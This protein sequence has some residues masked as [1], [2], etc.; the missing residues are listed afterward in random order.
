MIQCMNNL[1]HTVTLPSFP[2]LLIIILSVKFDWLILFVYFVHSETVR[3][4]Y[5]QPFVSTLTQTSPWIVRGESENNRHKARLPTRNRHSDAGHRDHMARLLHVRK[6]H[7]SVDCQKIHRGTQPRLYEC[8][9]RGQGVWSYHQRTLSQ[10]ALNSATEHALWSKTGMQT[11]GL[12][13]TAIQF[14]RCC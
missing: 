9:S 2:Y 3:R 11:H 1:N 13:F 4:T 6:F 12:I 8:A 5:I 14:M 10:Y 7:Q